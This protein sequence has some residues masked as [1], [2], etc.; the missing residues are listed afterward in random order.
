[1][2]RAVTLL[3]SLT[4]SLGACGG[5]DEVERFPYRFEVTSEGE[6]VEGVRVRVGPDEVGL[7]DAAG[8]VD[9]ELA[10]REGRQLP[11]AVE[12]PDGMRDP[13]DLRPVVLQRMRAVGD[14]AR[15]RRVLVQVECPPYEREVAVL[16]RV[17]GH[18][19]VPVL[20]NG[21][22]QARTDADGLA[23]L[24][25]RLEPGAPLEVS[26]RTDHLPNLLPRDPARTWEVP[27]HDEL[28]VF[29]QELAPPVASRRRRRR[30]GRADA[31]TNVPIRIE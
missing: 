16:V 25:M 2:R 6:G 19:D 12:C 31:G 11:L 26:L 3:L 13:S 29:D 9:A 30:R 28:F 18:A 21:V 14:A 20:V 8:A 27:D 1:M 15:L 24:A 5:D 17:R 22:E 4:L 23:H 7:T 10:G